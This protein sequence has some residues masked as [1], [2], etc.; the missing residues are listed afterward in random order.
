MPESK[1]VPV[2]MDDKLRE[3]LIRYAVR[4][5]DGIVSRTA[6]KAIAK[7]LKENL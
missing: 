1:I 5:D 4:E 6:R 2:R 7:F 3:Q